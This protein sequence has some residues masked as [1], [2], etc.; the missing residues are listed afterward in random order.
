MPSLLL[1][2]LSSFFCNPKAHQ[3]HKEH[4]VSTTPPPWQGGDTLKDPRRQKKLFV[5]FFKPLSGVIHNYF[6]KINLILQLQNKLIN[7]VSDD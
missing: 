7:T 3:E 1:F 5:K 4:N 2:F 6:E